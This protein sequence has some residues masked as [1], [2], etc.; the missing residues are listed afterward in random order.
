MNHLSVIQQCSSFIKLGKA[1]TCQEKQADG[2]DKA[3]ML[4]AVTILDLT[5][6]VILIEHLLMLGYRYFLARMSQEHRH[7]VQT[8]SPN[9]CS[10]SMVLAGLTQNLL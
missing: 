2:K 4:H 7:R 3:V 1:K 10:S 5:E 9:L 8:A 6:T